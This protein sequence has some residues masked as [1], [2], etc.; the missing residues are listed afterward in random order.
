MILHNAVSVDGRIDGFEPQIGLFYE[1]ARS[2][3]EDATLAG[4]DT[5][6]AAAAVSETAPPV[7]PP[8]NGPLLAVTDSRG[9]IG[10]WLPLLGAGIWRDVLSLCAR[11]T[12]RSYLGH[13]D[14]C[15]V[16]YA[17]CGDARVDLRA[18][19]ELLAQDH[20]ARTVRVDSGGLLNGALLRSGL[21]DEISLLVHPVVVG[22]RSPK[23][24]FVADD[25]PTGELG[26]ALA[27]PSIEQ[28]ADGLLWLRWRIEGNAGTRR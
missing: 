19:L 26:I 9:R 1:L 23:S 27:Q 16:R 17:Q 13:L 20:G 12:P 15:G 8:P 22:G 24:M 14:E 4:A 7:V 18:A 6:L 3:G 10:D 28:L 2:F 21:V 11:D 5:I 25:L